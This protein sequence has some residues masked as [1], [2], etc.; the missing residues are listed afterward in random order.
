MT[1]VESDPSMSF[2]SIFSKKI[3]SAECKLVRPQH[4][5]F[6]IVKCIISHQA[7]SYYCTSPKANSTIY[8]AW[9]FMF[10]GTGNSTYHNPIFTV[11]K[12]DWTFSSSMVTMENDMT[13]YSVNQIYINKISWTWKKYKF[14]MTQWILRLIKVLHN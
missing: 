6:C 4:F 10:F 14:S 5:N 7:G 11:Y 1:T 12:M 13:F 8:K 2:F 3:E 9:D